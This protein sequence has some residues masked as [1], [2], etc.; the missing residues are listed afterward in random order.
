MV[1]TKKTLRAYGSLTMTATSEGHG[2]FGVPWYGPASAWYSYRCRADSVVRLAERKTKT[3][4]RS[5]WIAVGSIPIGVVLLL[6]A[7]SEDRPEATGAASATPNDA[8]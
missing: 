3:M 4:R 2:V 7:C 1:A 5:W 6:V 8:P